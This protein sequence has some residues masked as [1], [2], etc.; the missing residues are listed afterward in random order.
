MAITLVE[1]V[2]AAN[3]NTY[4]TVAEADTYLEARLNSSPWTAAGT[5]TQKAALVEAT[6]EMDLMPWRGTRVTLTQA[7]AWPRGDVP[8][9]DPPDEVTVGSTSA[10]YSTTE[11]PDRIRDMTI[12]FA[13]EFL[14]AGSTDLARPDPDRDVIRKKI[15]VIETE[16]AKDRRPQGLAR[17]P[18]ILARLYPLLDPYR[19]GNEWVRV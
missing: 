14:R 12:E 17:F 19:V 6:R 4:A 16:W 10:E 13:L 1:T 9:P 15:D 5:E 7:L 2:G 11:I 18:R 3:A 8:I